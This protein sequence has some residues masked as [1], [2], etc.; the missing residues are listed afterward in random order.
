MPEAG[1]LQLNVTGQMDTFHSCFGQDKRPLSSF[2]S[3][4]R[5]WTARYSLCARSGPCPGERYCTFPTKN[6]QGSRRASK[7]THAKH[8]EKN[9]HVNDSMP[10]HTNEN[11]VRAHGHL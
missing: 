6:R 8:A 1:I 7:E 5:S 2:K 9:M 11:I 4:E 3:L 10:L